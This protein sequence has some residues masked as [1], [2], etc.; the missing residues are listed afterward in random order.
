[1]SLN[2]S[3]P[4]KKDLPCQ[5]MK[6]QAEQVSNR[7][8]PHHSAPIRMKVVKKAAAAEGIKEDRP[9]ERS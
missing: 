9:Q 6:V 7:G 1:M 2:R 3:S 5:S 8:A 4:S